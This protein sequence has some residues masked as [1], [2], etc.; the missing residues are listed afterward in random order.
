MPTSPSGWVLS[1]PA[2]HNQSGGHLRLFW[3]AN[4][5]WSRSNI[6]WYPLV[7]APSPCRPGALSPDRLTYFICTTFAPPRR[8]KTVNSKKNTENFWKPCQKPDNVTIGNTPRPK[9]GAELLR[10]IVFL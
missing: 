5:G 3:S 10:P 1:K 6:D 4:S 2:H 9:R 7:R 8:C